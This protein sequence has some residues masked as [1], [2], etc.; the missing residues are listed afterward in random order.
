M[1]VMKLYDVTSSYCIRSVQHQITVRG[2]AG[3]NSMQ[4]CSALAWYRAIQIGL[5]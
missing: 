2:A 4:Q 5:V 1:Y 3:L